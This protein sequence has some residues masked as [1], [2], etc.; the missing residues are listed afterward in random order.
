VTWAADIKEYTQSR[1]MPPWKPTSDFPLHGERRL[2]ETEI[3]ALAAWA[4]AGTPMGDPKTAPAPRRFTEGW[5]LGEPDLVLT[6]PEEFTLAASGPDVYRCFVLPTDLPEDKYVTAVEV[7]PGNRRAVHHAVIVY[8]AD[9][10]ARKLEEQEKERARKMESRDTGPGYQVPLALSFLPGFLPEGGLG[11]WAPGMVPRHLAEGT[12]YFLPKGADVVLQLHYHRTGRVEKDRTRVGVYF[13]KERENRRLRDVTVPGQFLYIPAGSESYK[14]EGTI[15]VRQD[16]EIHNIMP[17]MHLL[18]RTVKMTIISPEGK[19]R[20]LV[21]IRD[22]DFDWQELYFPREPIKVKSGTRFDIEATF[23]NSVKNARNPHS[24][25]R[26]VFPGMQTTN[27]MCV[28]FLCVTADKPGPV[29]FDVQPR[30]PGLKW[31]PNWGIP[32]IG[33]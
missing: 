7:R 30:I 11:G 25:P 24:P 3:A 21:D 27:E 13:S 12:G 10:R 2:S 6:V 8:D 15:W 28:G 16:C 20:T 4:D 18:G 14:V 17:H 23:D 9:G 1:K 5:Q 33:F 29:R 19:P 26:N 32:G 31:R 22:W